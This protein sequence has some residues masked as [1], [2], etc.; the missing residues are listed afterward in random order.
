MANGK[1]VYT[2]VAVVVLL[3]VGW[4]CGL[5]SSK[6]DPNTE[7]ASTSTEGPPQAMP[8]VA[9]P[10][11]GFGAPGSPDGAPVAPEEPAPPEEGPAPEEGTVPSEETTP[12]GEASAPAESEKAPT[13]DEKAPAESGDAASAKTSQ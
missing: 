4:A 13:E 11:E 5:F 9:P 10:A 1:L 3:A 8:E 2:V 7:K 6:E 12:P